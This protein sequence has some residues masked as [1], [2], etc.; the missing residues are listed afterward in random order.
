MDFFQGMNE[1]F[2]ISSRE[3]VPYPLKKEEFRIIIK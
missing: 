1:V 3:A 2:A